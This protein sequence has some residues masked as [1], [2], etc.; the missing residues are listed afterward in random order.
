MLIAHVIF[1]I[2]CR[3]SPKCANVA[4]E[5]V[6][7]VRQ[8]F[9]HLVHAKYELATLSLVGAGYFDELGN[10][11]E[12]D[13]AQRWLA[14]S[15]TRTASIELRLTFCADAVPV[16]AYVDVGSTHSARLDTNRALEFTKQLSVKCFKCFSVHFK[17]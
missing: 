17:V 1:H 9:N 7:A 13:A 11:L 3:T 15:A 5:S 4:L 14:R 16:D 6:A 12:L 2:S 8:V 10:T